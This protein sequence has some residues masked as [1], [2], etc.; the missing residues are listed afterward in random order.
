MGDLEPSS[1][2]S[3]GARL[4]SCNAAVE[5]APE[6]GGD[7]EQAAVVLGER[8]EMAA[9]DLTHLVG[10]RRSR[11]PRRWRRRRRAC[12]RRAA[13]HHLAEEGVAS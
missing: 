5:L 10:Q 9:D 7:R 8:T 6:H 4:A 1:T 13:G 3:A 11:R 2:R 12:L